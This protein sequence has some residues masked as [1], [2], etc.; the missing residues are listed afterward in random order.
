MNNNLPPSQY[1]EMTPGHFKCKIIQSFYVSFY[2]E[3]YIFTKFMLQIQLFTKC[4]RYCQYFS[5]SLI[6]PLQY[7]F[8]ATW[9]FF[10]V[11][12]PNLFNFIPL[13]GHV[14]CFL[15]FPCFKGCDDD[16]V[17]RKV[18]PHTSGNFLWVNA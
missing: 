12:A 7:N 9:C 15:S 13:L 18:F 5:M 1:L 11:E 14:G 2:V 8:M 6:I 3:I 4:Y 16:Y 17:Y 10:L